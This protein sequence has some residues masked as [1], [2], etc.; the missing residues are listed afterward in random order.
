MTWAEF[1]IHILKAQAQTLHRL[2][3]FFGEAELIEMLETMGESAEVSQL[4]FQ[5]KQEWLPTTTGPDTPSA[6]L[7][8]EG[9]VHDMHLSSFL[10]FHLWA[11]PFYRIIIESSANL[12]AK[13]PDQPGSRVLE[14]LVEEAIVQAQIWTRNLPIPPLLAIQTKSIAQ[15][16]W[17][18]FRTTVLGKIGR[19]PVV[20]LD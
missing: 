15:V 18:R 6:Y 4:S 14:T 13:I 12:K 2:A 17:V 10:E 16:P 1:L 5:M 9:A 20:A 8:L 3:A 11:Y 19:R 7:E